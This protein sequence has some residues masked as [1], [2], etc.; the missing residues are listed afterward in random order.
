MAKGWVRRFAEEERR[1]DAVERREVDTVAEQGEAV[2]ARSLALLDALRTQVA[3]DVKAFSRE[4]PGRSISFEQGLPGGGFVVRRGHYPEVHL[5]VVPNLS[6]SAI[7]VQYLLASGTGTEAPPPRELVVAGHDDAPHFRD[8]ESQQAF[9]KIEQLSEY[10]LVPVFVG[11][12]RESAQA[13][14]GSTPES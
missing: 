3:R 14:S 4:F 7:S 2:R 9:R 5:T 13:R 8:E 11:R 6:G 12:L 10:L 1:R